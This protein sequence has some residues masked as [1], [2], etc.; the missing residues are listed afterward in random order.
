MQGYEA[1]RSGGQLPCGR[2][3]WRLGGYEWIVAAAG[4][5]WRNW[6]IVNVV[7]RAQPVEGSAD[8]LI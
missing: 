3:A 4:G 5:D 7:Q 6:S 8:L 1:W 2:D